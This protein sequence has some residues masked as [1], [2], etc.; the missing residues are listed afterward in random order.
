MRTVS[1]AGQTFPQLGGTLD[2]PLFIVT[3]TDGRRRE[4][5]V[6]GFATQCSIHPPRF[7]ACL[8]RENR[9]FRVACEAEALAV[10]VLPRGQMELARLFGGQTGDDVDKFARCEWTPGPRGLPIL[11]GCPTWFAG[12]IRERHDFGDHVGFVLEPIDARV[13]QGVE[14]V[15]FQEVKDAIAPGHPVA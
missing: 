8:S 4:G 5:C 12:E 9:T 15:F 14:A 1:D 2:Y 11:D 13:G 6:I 3:V 10:H 7:L